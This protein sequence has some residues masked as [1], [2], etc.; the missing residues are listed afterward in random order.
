MC[1]CVCVLGLFSRAIA[2]S[3]LN[4][5]SWALPAYKGVARN[6]AKQL[7]EHFDC[8]EFNNWNKTIECLRNNVSA[9]E[10][11]AALYNFFV[12]INQ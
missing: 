9:T 7:A 11:T 6:R 12:N 4:T 3:G 5:A 2:Q 10:I 1:M 8:Y